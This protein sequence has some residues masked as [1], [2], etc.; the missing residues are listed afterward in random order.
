MFVIKQCVVQ[1]KWVAI[2]KPLLWILTGSTRTPGLRDKY[3][4]FCVHS[5]STDRHADNSHDKRL[6]CAAA[7]IHPSLCANVLEKPI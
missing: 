2:F 7:A 3:I 1:K 5:V 4:Y 6:E